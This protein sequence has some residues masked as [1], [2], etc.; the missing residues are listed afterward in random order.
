MNY[1]EHLDNHFI[2]DEKHLQWTNKVNN[3]QIEYDK[4]DDIYS[5]FIQNCKYKDYE[6]ALIENNKINWVKIYHNY[7]DKMP[8]WSKLPLLIYLDI[9]CKL[10]E[11]NFDR[12]FELTK[13]KS[14]YLYKHNIIDLDIS[15]VKSYCN[16]TGCELKL[17]YS[18]IIQHII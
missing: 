2:Y 10:N 9:F 7:N 1:K 13:L 18:E 4:E 6:Q 12:L 16:M 15:N 5:L 8:D 11:N 3:F 14:I 17:Y